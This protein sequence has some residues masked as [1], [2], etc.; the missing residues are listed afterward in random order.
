MG[1]TQY[2]FSAEQQERVLMSSAAPRTV[3]SETSFVVMA[4][5]E[6]SFLLYCLHTIVRVIGLLKCYIPLMHVLFA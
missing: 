3:M 6:K 4:A 5:E 1:V 2:T